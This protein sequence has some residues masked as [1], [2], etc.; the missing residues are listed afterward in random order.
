M[1]HAPDIRRVVVALVVLVHAVATRPVNADVRVTLEGGLLSVRASGEPLSRVL[2]VF[3][4]ETGVEFVLHDTT[5]APVSVTIER[6]PLAQAL[7][8]LF[9]SRST[10]LVFAGR[11]ARSRLAAV[12]VLS[13]EAVA[14]ETTAPGA[15]GGDVP[16][17][18]PEVL[19]LITILGRD[20]SDLVRRRAA[21]TLGARHVPE[22]L[23]PLATSATTDDDAGVRERA[24]R[25]LGSSWDA[26]AVDPLAKALDDP[27]VYVREQAA[28][29][30]GRLWAAE[31]VEPLARAATSDPE[32]MV[33]E[34]A[35][36]ALART[37][38][39]DAV[40]PLAQVL[41]DD[42]DSR[43]REVAAAALDSLGLPGGHRVLEAA[44]HDPHPIV[45][46]RVAEALGR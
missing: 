26:K 33:R 31:A 6:Q 21:A 40:G 27:D 38:S 37:W 3:A 2:R 14:G 1:R 36:T 30:L 42:P 34:A 39:D 7:E 45:R 4:A 18:D 20:D 15:A 5:D 17:V 9:R 10:L 25:A 44:V 24:V 43:V 46:R 32:S 12:H 19:A 41:L 13:A 29:S 8:R 23:D 35:V 22:A 11:G 28:Q 16:A